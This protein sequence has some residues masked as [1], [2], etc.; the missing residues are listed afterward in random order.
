VFLNG[1]AIPS[2][3]PRGNRVVDDSFYLLFNAHVEALPFRL[4]QRP[5]WGES[6][7]RVLDTAEGFPQEGGT[8]SAGSEVQ[9]EARSVVLL[10]RM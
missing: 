7:V 8:V 9:V 3:D 4:P 2:L 5:E 1:Q 6:W 10:K